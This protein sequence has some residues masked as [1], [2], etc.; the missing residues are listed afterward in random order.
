M[1][2]PHRATLLAA[3]AENHEAVA[4]SMVKHRLQRLLDTHLSA[5]RLHALV[6]LEVNGP[7]P[8]GDLA[9][10]LGVSAATVTGLVD[11]LEKAGLAERRTDPDDGRSRIVHVT[12]AGVAAWRDAVLG[13]TELDASVLDRLSDDDLALIARAGAALRR[14]V[15]D[16]TE[17]D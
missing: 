17:S 10:A 14:A 2:E 13:P 11:G 9:R 7:Q 6:V 5:A 16:V 15:T 4:S 3:I 1:P 8:A 12:A